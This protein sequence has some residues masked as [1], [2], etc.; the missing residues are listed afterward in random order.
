[1]AKQLNV[2]LAVTA[3]TTQAKAELS[4][5][6]NQLTNLVNNAGKI[7]LAAGLNTTELSKAVGMTA[8]LSQ[9]LKN[10]TNINTGTLNFTQLQKSLVSSGKSITAYGE[11][12]LQL[13]PQGQQAFT[14]LATAISK[15]EVPL[16]R[17]NTLLG[18]FWTTLK[19]TARWQISSSMLHTFM[20]S[21][22]SAYRY[23][24]DLNQSLNRIQ[25]VTGASDEHMAK[26]AE[27]ANKAAQ[28]L[29]TTTTR[30][31]D[32]SLIYYQ[33]G[34]SDKEVAARAET[35]IKLANVS[36]QSAEKVSDQMTAIWNNFAK[37][38]E[39]LEYYADV[40]TALGAA[41]AS[42]SEEIAT[43]LEKFAAI[44][45]T[46]GLSYE[47]ASAALAT[48][49]ATTRQSADTVG[50]GLR[51]L[52]SRLQSVSLGKTLEDGVN[53]TKYSK[54]LETVG[55]SVLDAT[56]NLRDM[57]SILD[58]L[59]EKWDTL[60]SAQQTALAQTVGGVRQ[61]TTL[62]ALMDNYDFYK[63]NLAVAKGS[64]GT[65]QQQADIYAKSWEAAS[66]RMRASFEAIVSDVLDDKAFVGIIDFFSNVLSLVDKLIDSLGGLK[67]IIFA[68]GSYLTKMY[69]SKVAEMFT[70][71]IYNTVSLFKSGQQAIDSDRQSQLK[72]L[73]QLQKDSSFYDP[74]SQVKATNLEEE[75]KLQQQLI[76]QA[77]TMT[78]KEREIAQMRLDGIRQAGEAYAQLTASAS[79]ARQKVVTETS[80]FYQ[81]VAAAAARNP[82]RYG[83][84]GALQNNGSYQLLMGYGNQ[85]G[86]SQYLG[87]LQALQAALAPLNTDLTLTASSFNYIS[88]AL[89]GLGDNMINLSNLSAESRNA[90]NNFIDEF[91]ALETA[92]SQGGAAN[93]SIFV[94][95][96]QELIT[97]LST[98]TGSLAGTLQRETGA[99]PNRMIQA[100]Q[101]SGGALFKQLLG[102][103][104]LE[105]LRNIGIFLPNG[106]EDKPQGF[107][108]KAANI[109]KSLSEISKIA[110]QTGMAI[111]AMNNMFQVFGDESSS[112]GEKAMAALTGLPMIISGVST[113]FQ[114][115][116]DSSTAA[117]GWIGLAVMAISLVVKIIDVANESTAEKTQRLQDELKSTE[118]WAKTAKNAL[119]DLTEAKTSHNSMLDQL[120]SLKEGTVEFYDAL[121]Q[122]NTAAN[123]LIG[124]YNLTYGKDQDWYLGSSGEILFT[125]QAN[126]T[127][128]NMARRM[129]GSSMLQTSMAQLAVNKQNDYVQKE[130]LL[131]WEN[132]SSFALLQSILKRNSTATEETLAEALRGAISSI[133][134]SSPQQFSDYERLNRYTIEQTGQDFIT[135]LINQ[136]STLP[137]TLEDSL[138][139]FYS[140]GARVAAEDT[141]LVR[142]ALQGY[143]IA[144]GQDTYGVVGETI[145]DSLFAQDGASEKIQGYSSQ[146]TNRAKTILNETGRSLLD[147]QQLYT[148]VTGEVTD[149]TNMDMLAKSI[150]RYQ[151]LEETFGKDYM[152]QLSAYEKDEGFDEFVKYFSEYETASYE[153]LQGMADALRPG[154]EYAKYHDLFFSKIEE[155]MKSQ[156]ADAKELLNTLG[157]TEE[158][159]I[160]SNFSRTDLANLNNIRKQIDSL[161]GEDNT[162]ST[163][164]AKKIINSDALGHQLVGALQQID[165]SSSLTAVTSGKRMAKLSKL[166]GSPIADSLGEM[167]QTIAD[168]F[169]DTELLEE[170]GKNGDFQK[171]LKS[172]QD[173]F[174]K[175]GKIGAQEVLDAADSC[176]ILSEAIEY[177]E[178]SAGAM[179]DAIEL[180]TIGAISGFDDMNESLWEMLETLNGFEDSLANAFNYIDDWNNHL[181]RSTQDLSD[182]FSKITKDV[183]ELLH[184]GNTG[185]ER[186][187]QQVAGLFGDNYAAN[188]RQF[189]FNQERNIN[190]DNPAAREAA[191]EAR[192]GAIDDI[193]QTAQTEGNNRAIWEGLLTGAFDN[194]MQGKIA[195]TQTI[196]RRGGSQDLMADIMG[197]PQGMIT[198]T[199]LSGDMNVSKALNQIGFSLNDNNDI[200]LDTQGRTTAQMQAALALAMGISN[201]AAGVWLQELAGHSQGI[202]QDLKTNDYMAAVS[203]WNQQQKTGNLTPAEIE[204]G[205]IA[206]AQSADRTTVEAANEQVEKNID[207]ATQKRLEAETAL[208][209]ARTE[210]NT[211]AEQQ[212]QSQLNAAEAEEEKLRGQKKELEEI[213]ELH[214]EIGTATEKILSHTGETESLYSEL[215]P[216]VQKTAKDLLK[217]SSVKVGRKEDLG[218]DS[219]KEVYDVNGLMNFY[220]NM[221]M[222][223]EQA[224]QTT[225][226]T[227]ND[228]TESAKKTGETMHELAVTAT[229]EYGNIYSES[230]NAADSVEDVQKAIQ[231][232][233]A[234]AK[235]GANRTLGR[236]LFQGFVEQ[237]TA[238]SEELQNLKGIKAV[239]D[240]EVKADTKQAQTDINDIS[241]EEPVDIEVTDNKTVATTQS[242][243][244][245]IH[246]HSVYI[247]V[248]A[249]T[250]AA[251]QAIDTWI[252]RIEATK[253]IKINLG[254]QGPATGGYVA[255]SYATGSA[256]R[257]LKPGLSLTAEEGPEIIWNKNDGYSYMV[258]GNGHPEFVVLRPGDRVFNANQTREILNYDKPDSNYFN[259]IMDPSKLDSRLFGSYAS[260]AS[261]YGSYGQYGGKSKKSKSGG[262]G[263]SSKNSKTKEFDPERY[264]VLTR[265]IQDLT[266]WYEELEKAREHAYGTNILEA[267][268]KETDALQ[269]QEKAQKA[270]L[271][272]AERYLDVDL[273]RLKELNVDYL[274]DEHGNIANWDELQDKYGEAAQKGEDENAVNAWKAIQQYEE[275]V[276]KWQE[277]MSDLSDLQY[278]IA[279]RMLEAVTTKVDLKID[280]D[281]RDLKLIEHFTDKIDDNIYDSAKVLS[282]IGQ[283]LNKIN[284]QIATTRDGINLIFAN[285]TDAEGNPITGLTLEAF[286][287]MSQAERDALNIN[288]DFGKQ[289]EEYSE[290]ILDYIEDLEDFRTKG[291]EELSDGFEELSNN[292]SDALDLFDH[293]EGILD[294][295]KNIVDL[296]GITLSED[297]YKTIDKMN[298][299]ILKNTTNNIKSELRYY[300]TLENEVAKLRAQVEKET[301]AT[302]KKEWE[303]QLKTAEDALR[304]EQNNLLELWQNGLD[305][306]KTIFET[307]IDNIV[308]R[309]ETTISN[310]YGN[311][312]ELQKAYDRKKELGEFYVDD[313][314]KYYQIAKLQR[315]IN[316]DLDDAA[317][318][319][320]KANKGLKALFDELNAARA[321][322]V[323]LT[324]YD[325]DI[326]AKRYEYE[327]AMMELEDA[328]NAKS[329]VRL[330]R[331]ANGNWGYVYTAA[332]D[333]DDIIARQQAAD[334]ALY[335]WQKAAVSRSK[336]LTDQII[337][338]FKNQLNELESNYKNGVGNPED[339]LNDI[340]QQY[341]NMNGQL[342][343]SLDDANMTLDKAKDRYGNE[344]FDILDLFSET[345]L[346]K[347]LDTSGGIDAFFDKLFNEL[348]K[349]NTLM[350]Q[351]NDKYDSNI[352]SINKYFND[353]GKDLSAVISGWA[354]SIDKDSNQTVKRNKE[355]IDNAK[356][357]FDEILLAAQDFENEFMKTYDPIISRNEEFLTQ[358]YAVLDGLNRL[359]YVDNN[360]ISDAARGTFQDPITGTAVSMD[361][362]GYT[363]SWGR[364]GKLAILH[365]KEEVFNADD[366]FR[367][368]KAAK[369]LETIDLQS[370]LFSA[371]LRNIISPQVG[372]IGQELDQHVDIS[373]S[374]PNVTDHN[375]IELA[376][377]NLINKASQYANRKNLAS[378]NFSDMYTSKF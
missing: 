166:V 353:S 290:D 174:K 97:A 319:G 346:D 219:A 89:L 141:G 94:E 87:G 124:K 229:D 68:I 4:N 292:I 285:M 91:I 2:N 301:N 21:L 74:V 25:I 132:Q 337:S 278:D 1:M 370:N 130:D 69:S 276:D 228:M 227:Y 157:L 75:L 64:E 165:F 158:D 168:Q 179:A 61:Y 284:D 161:F 129:V 221:G 106:E 137:M 107:A 268:N 27:N 341:N 60:S 57:D 95:R 211:E 18:N 293:Y 261:A 262:G 83:N 139:S 232:V 90:L 274:L 363:G 297:L 56:G 307:T 96:L 324:A 193:L 357:T 32:A 279:D 76:T 105:Q 189:F 361:S 316:K 178:L 236:D 85:T 304:E 3:D 233:E 181:D 49:T 149:E 245:A 272:E 147:L 273:K 371:G 225:L 111:S 194:E 177:G 40:I 373:A 199:K 164:F 35:T 197:L 16:S 253:K 335:E 342:T 368:L 6:Q 206:L 53:L 153:E 82:E 260:G 182:H 17:A 378:M 265:Q 146:V 360:L 356:S 314:E 62:I 247:P 46:V 136:R 289:L 358:L 329:E 255:N 237:A 334:D 70:K 326:F 50:T 249:N 145:L 201:D 246:G 73:I 102:K 202:T 79:E 267:I 163:D 306:A 333:E 323:E 367:I 224:W 80:N 315:Q 33:Q 78:E 121:V 355:I 152:E 71:G 275:T 196:Y 125:D 63:E 42:S 234:E 48:I 309:V 280:F 222:S 103:E 311:L 9:H 235:H 348:N 7:N 256:N 299:S 52:F 183:F 110:M 208:A 144:N 254:T 86:I 264:H 212:A 150:A 131:T 364:S 30:Y 172:L 142:Q 295:L 22:Q 209:K 336:E 109:G 51:T 127:M 23:A 325:L 259:A 39:N 120:K 322:G 138:N 214:G 344:F 351:A 287:K 231:N 218:K 151:V 310:S 45:D 116:A 238:M 271:A 200:E 191:Y 377:D 321:D 66:T 44:A 216:E 277:V 349:A 302:L 12:L 240:V 286:L 345:T 372:N 93:L 37:G 203:Q 100:S 366:T 204:A 347:V 217:A 308:R 263:S 230:V 374:F 41:T 115:M 327:K 282:L 98:E 175:T 369:I 320:N 128:E 269:E 305:Q 250:F 281:D 339:L 328:R 104:G 13:G 112:A 184:E 55:I 156:E 65:V 173:T 28:R 148:D 283:S 118:E 24:Q 198:R 5:L 20:G 291:V 92:V 226:E 126:T 365:E 176:D 117:F 312:D 352:N 248:N 19:N 162:I 38:G 376:F 243:I 241:R 77:D 140:T 288:Q 54:A 134:N 303:D 188:M 31:T 210:G 119:N 215:G 11:Q 332:A 81:T 114:M 257:I 36:G 133:E 300:N 207:A 213:A 67:P 170:L 258:G 350:N 185:G 159:N 187:Y 298:D 251:E 195:T 15:S 14:S 160:L 354:S 167:V 317:K 270:L 362:G 252:A 123:E 220:Q 155:A 99:D 331:D 113:A 72:S 84:V 186:L 296:Q 330:H 108:G 34:L 343:K 29:S 88:A 171:S 294:N 318:N 169:K 205:K 338:N 242:L 180:M 375:E 59:G 192:Y 43:G 244:D 58:D 154:G 190:R 313:Y 359:D 47:N 122:A 340:L 10:A 26:F 239:V 143:A 266:F 135:T 8:E 223:A 101:S